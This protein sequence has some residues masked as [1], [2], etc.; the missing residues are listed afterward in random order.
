MRG[1]RDNS[2]APFILYLSIRALAARL[3]RKISTLSSKER[4]EIGLNKVMK[5]KIPTP[6]SKIKP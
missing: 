4:P 1:R 6:W 5:R 3:P 2:K